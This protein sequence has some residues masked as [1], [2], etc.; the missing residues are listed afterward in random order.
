M[1]PAIL[2]NGDKEMG[3]LVLFMKKNKVKRENIHIPA[4]KSLLGADG[5][6]VLWEVRHLTT[7]EAN[8]I[9]EECSRDIPVTGKPGMFRNKL[10]TNE[11]LAKLASAAVVFPDLNDKALQ[12][13]YGVM[14]P[15]EL[16]FEMIDDPTEFNEFLEKIQNMSGID[17]TLNDKVEEAKN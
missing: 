4:T 8:D 10:N 1:P 9:R 3:D 2:R 14:T 12:D 16:I 7:R 5:K 13:S 15:E 11:Y 6:P 17:K